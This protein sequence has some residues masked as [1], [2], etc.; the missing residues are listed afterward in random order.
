[1]LNTPNPALSGTCFSCLLAHV[2]AH[3]L[4]G[5]ALTQV[6]HVL[7]SAQIIFVLLPPLSSFEL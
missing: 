7:C 3:A 1:M 2:F 4:H 5:S 6:L